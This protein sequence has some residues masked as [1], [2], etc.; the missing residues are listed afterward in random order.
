[1]TVAK[2]DKFAYHKSL[3]GADLTDGEYRVLATL[4][5]YASPDGTNAHPGNKVLAADCKMS[6]SKVE[7]ALVSLRAKD[8]IYQDMPGRSRGRGGGG[9]AAVY[10]L[11]APESAVTDD[12]SLTAESAVMFDG[13]FP[14][15]QPSNGEES[16]VILAESAVKT[17]GINRHSYDAPPDQLHQI[18]KTSDQLAPNQ[19]RN[20]PDALTCVTLNSGN[21]R[22][23]ESTADH[24]QALQADDE[25]EQ[26]RQDTERERQRQLREY[27]ICK[28]CRMNFAAEGDLCADC[29]Q[30]TDE[31]SYTEE[32]EMAL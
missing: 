16:T 32:L 24:L 7:R 30:A 8:W 29:W 12:G 11:T 4:W 10:R 20:S 31:D 22:E 13:S 1:M 19:L 21:A 5:D 18:K 25:R 17:D 14:E 27:V 6:P 26:E 28:R 23:D 9:F 3:R 2:F 15:N